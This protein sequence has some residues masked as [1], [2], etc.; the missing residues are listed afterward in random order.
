M[1]AFVSKGCVFA[2]SALLLIACDKPPAPPEPLRPVKTLRIS[3]ERSENALNL[4]GEVRARH[5]AP[6]AFR[7]GGKIVECQVNLGD[8]V[9]RGQVLARLEP[10]DYDLAAQAAAAGEAEARSASILADADLA[11]Y[12][13]L[14][15][16]GFVSPAALDQKQAVTDAAHAR[17]DVLRSAHT[18]QSRQVNYTTLTSE[19]DGIITGL[20]CNAG[21]V[22]SAG[23]PVLH[24]AQSAEKEVAVHL[25]ESEFPRFRSADGFTVNL[26]ALPDKGYLGKLRELAAA[27]D[28]ATRTFAARI[29]VKNADA[30]MQLGMSATVRMQSAGDLAIRLPLAA[31][32]SRDGKPHVWQVDEAGIVHATPIAVAATEGNMVRIASGLSGGN[33]VVIAG[34]S[35]LRDGEKV[36]LLP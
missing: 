27:A 4:P 8:T 22:I 24:L 9:R 35:L 33:T 11:R 2:M 29:A 19:S 26:N 31:V 18:G 36:K 30:A 25:P 5:E 3:M 15:E 21:Q 17:L 14:R 7:V 23:L 34:A 16:K 32:V 20:N 28:P 10:N 1:A 13:N 12:R 6:L